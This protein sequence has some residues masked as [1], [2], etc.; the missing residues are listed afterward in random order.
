MNYVEFHIGGKSRGFKFGLGFLGDLI[1]HYNT[2]LSGLGRV[3]VNN[4]FSVAPACL[5]YAHYHDCAR[6]G[7]PVDFTIHDAQDWMDEL[8]DP[9]NDK[10]VAG[11]IKVAVATITRYLPKPEEGEDQKKN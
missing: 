3:M 9:L 4:P 10:N 11:A 5:Y 8:D 6:K 7:V 2:D 1:Q